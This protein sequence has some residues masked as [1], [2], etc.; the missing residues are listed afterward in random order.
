MKKIAWIGGVLAGLG[1]IGFWLAHNQHTKQAQVRAAALPLPVAVAVQPVRR[2][3]LSTETEY[4]GQSTYWR[5]VLMTATT[6]GIVRELYVRLH[7]SVR[8]GQALLRVDS[9]VAEAS[10]AVAE[11]TL[12]KARQ[13]LARYELLQRENNATGNEV[14]KARLDVR[15]A[16]FQL[17]SL[18]KQVGDALV[19][20]PIGGTLTEKPIEPGMFIA[21]G[22]PLATITDVSS[23]KVTIY[24]P[25]AE[26]RDWSPGRVVP[27]RF[28][29]YPDV[30][31]RGSVHHI[32][33]KGGEAGTS[34]PGRFPVEIRV[35]NTRADAPL[36][37]G[38]TAHV[39]RRETAARPVLTIPRAA[40][41][42]TGD[43]PAVYVLKG[44]Q[45]RLRPIQL[46]DRHGTDLIVNGG[47]QP[48]ERV[49]VSGSAGLRDGQLVVVSRQSLVD[50]RQ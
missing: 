47:L 38:M 27:L 32:G 1:G 49:V 5:E 21:P 11:V 35:A 31:F 39:S 7:G 48:G 3:T 25:E 42:Q 24:V 10:R 9:D 45:A 44:R 41:T 30:P 34:V 4:L 22:T 8:A 40:L 28:E 6:Q 36:R 20:A 17:I 23:V 19:K 18:Q 13:D 46:G 16:E 33:L 2:Q 37:V 14:E 43:T 50:S 12:A 29:A 15:N 26:L